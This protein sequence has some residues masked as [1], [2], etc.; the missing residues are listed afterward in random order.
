[1]TLAE[2][3]EL[4]RSNIDLFESDYVTKRGEHPNPN[5]A[6]PLSLTPELWFAQLDIWFRMLESLGGVNQK[7]SFYSET[8][9]DEDGTVE[10]KLENIDE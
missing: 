3:C 10:F 1:M 5:E 9:V 4:V 6:Y 8:E 7:K 2:F